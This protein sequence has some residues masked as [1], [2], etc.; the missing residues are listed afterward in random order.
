MPTPVA[1]SAALPG[2]LS[3]TEMANALG[4]TTRTVDRLVAG[5]LPYARLGGKRV[6]SAAVVADWLSARSVGRAA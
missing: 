3:K 2:V 5:G 4:V 1:L 6:F